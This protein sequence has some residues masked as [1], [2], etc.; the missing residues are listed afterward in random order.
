MSSSG[1]LATDGRRS[2]DAGSIGHARRMRLRK[3]SAIVFA[4]ITMGY[5]SPQFLYIYDSLAEAGLA[6]VL[7]EEEEPWRPFLPLAG[8]RRIL[9]RRGDR[10]R[11]W[12]RIAVTLALRDVRVVVLGADQPLPLPSVL[13]RRTRVAR[14]YYEVDD[15]FD[16][17]TGAYP[18]AEPTLYGGVAAE[19]GA[20]GKV[21]LR[22]R[23]HSVIERRVRYDA[24]LAPQENRL[25]LARGLY[26]DADRFFLVRNAAPLETSSPRQREDDGRLTVVC[27]GQ[28]NGYTLTA[29]LLEV[30]AELG[31][32]FRF[33]VAGPA[34][35][36]AQSAE[37]TR[38]GAAG[39]VEYKGW[40]RRDEIV[41]VRREADIGLVLWRQVNLATR[42]ACPN[43]LFEFIADG[44][45]IV[46]TPNDSL[47]DLN[48]QYRFGLLMRDF[49]ADALKEA[50][51]ALADD[52]GLRREIG[53]R[54]R[55]THL[56]DLNWEAQSRAVVSY[57]VGTG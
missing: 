45:P 13:L 27:Q 50:L 42:Y 40:L 2:A 18:T 38:L 36:P 46:A 23:V 31:G 37:L 21:R 32:R 53:R 4:P 20:V 39:L 24:V 1:E 5:G 47:V 25:E 57:L 44:T 28:L 49:S 19:G 55:E 30:I 56:A 7:F 15:D 11:R 41:P 3:A 29:E 12:L 8:Y 48:A 10:L 9:L 16:W 22:T 51:L 54:N 14:Y 52:P 34:D 6:P 33:V 35:E 17:A 26:P 43:K